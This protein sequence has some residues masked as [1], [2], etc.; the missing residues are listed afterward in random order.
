MRNSS[1]CLLLVVFFVLPGT[2]S[3][4]QDGGADGKEANRRGD[5]KLPRPGEGENWQVLEDVKSGLRPQP[6]FEFQK[7]EEPEFVREMVRV[8]WRTGDPIDL[9]VLRPK[10]S[11]KVPVVL[12]LYSFPSD[13]AQ[14]RDD[15]WGK[16]ATAQGFAAVAFVS[17]LTGQRYHQ[18]PM[19]QWFLTEL[20]ESLGSSVHD[21]Q[22]IL[23]YLTER[24]DM[25]MEHVGMIGIGSGATIAILAAHAD[26]RIKALDLLDPWGDWLDWLRDSPAIPDEERAKYTA[27]EFLKSVA[28]LDPVAYL[29]SLKTP[30]RLRQ[31]L[32][33]PV[34]PKSAREKI[35]TS[36]RDPRLLTRYAN[37]EVLA[38]T[39]QVE[40]LSGWIKQLLRSQMQAEG[41]TGGLTAPGSNSAAN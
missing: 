15:G 20:P 21:V 12:Y 29:P 19:K 25:D 38:Q 11:G 2:V 10:T 17:A 34:M 16:R 31:T 22:L 4:Q 5:L 33:E 14:F 40:G 35:A 26:P 24:G 23:N 1:F 7:D 8:Q 41:R 6:P 9:Y 13:S 3:A 18:R 30:L 27:P 37:P 32:S 39:W 36:L 28:K